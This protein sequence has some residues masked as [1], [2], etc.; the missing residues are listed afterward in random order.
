MSTY[1][2]IL[3]LLLYETFYFTA[4][5]LYKPPEFFYFRTRF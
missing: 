5:I 3:V 2:K 1:D 4:V